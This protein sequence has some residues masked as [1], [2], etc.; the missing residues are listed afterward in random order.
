MPPDA[1]EELYQRTTA[2]AVMHG[3]VAVGV[4][5]TEPFVDTREVL[6]Q[7]RAD[8]LAAEMHFTFARP[9]RST[10]V[11]STYPWAERLVV[12]AV[13]Y[14]PAAGDP[15]PAVPGT[16]RIARFATEDHYAPLGNAL[17]AVAETLSGEGFRSGILMDDNRLVDRAA[18]VR[19][20][21]GWWGKNTMVLRPKHGPWT[22]LGSVATDARFAP[23]PPMQRT[24]GTC[25]A[26]LPACPTNAI[27]APGVLDA[28]LCIAY[29][30]QA[31]GMIPRPI[32]EVWGD[33]LYGC[34]DCLE[35]CPPGDRLMAESKEPEGRVDLLELMASDDVTLEATYRR[36][37]VPRRQVRYLR[38]NAVVALA[39]AP[40]AG[41]EDAIVAATAS[42]DDVVRAH[43][44]WS[45]AWA[46]PQRARTVLPEIRAA[47][48]A[49][50][51]LA[52]ID[53]ALD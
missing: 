19:A 43:A 25:T 41:V 32:R 10:D 38:R 45:L 46:Y 17:R 24:C 3:A 30:A 34:D 9:D 21:I 51:V 1:L 7:R 11:R 52:E 33:R 48:T 31:A 47:E 22:L 8:G 14:L 44:V 42:P 39:H 28:R 16:G 53:Q 36:F 12:L 6:A 49:P 23:T 18:A 26:C 27:V 29:W 15:G 5:T 37:Y 50:D 20:G 2:A 40:G 4:C 13:S 35:A